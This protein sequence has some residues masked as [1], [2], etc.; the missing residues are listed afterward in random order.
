[1]RITVLLLMSG[2]MMAAPSFA[3]TIQYEVNS[4][5]G[6]QYK[7]I[8]SL[9]G[10][11]FDANEEL[12]IDFTPALFS[13]LSNQAV[14]NGFS[15]MLLQPNNPP[16]ASGIYSAFTAAAVATPTGTF[17]VD[18]TFIGAGTPGDVPFYLNQYDAN[19][20]L[21]S[22][23]QS[24]WTTTRVTQASGVPEP[25]SFW[26]AAIALLIACAKIVISRR[27]ARSVV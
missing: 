19:Q 12:E 1:M 15:G 23:V 9:F 14:G 11:S 3:G 18:V 17:S 2:L 4:L 24:G 20:S 5:S 8:F 26:L 7:Y 16:G 10:M 27:R 13:S 25:G 21:L 6:N 22:T